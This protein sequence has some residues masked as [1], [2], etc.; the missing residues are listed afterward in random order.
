MRTIANA[1]ATITLAHVDA[2]LIDELTRSRRV[3]LP[4][5]L[6]D[7]TNRN[8]CIAPTWGPPPVVM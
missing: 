6:F 5:S 2:W 1:V 4:L 7:E 3:G 8:R